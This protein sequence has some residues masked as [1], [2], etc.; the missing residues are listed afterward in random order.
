MGIVMKVKLEII[1]DTPD[2]I[3]NELEAKDWVYDNLVNFAVCEHYFKALKYSSDVTPLYDHH[4]KA[5]KIIERS[6][7]VYS[8]L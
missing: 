1:L 3:E 4:T 7:R 5:A 8:V 6:N 2:Y